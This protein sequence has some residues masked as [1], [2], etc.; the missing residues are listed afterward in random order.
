M[1]TIQNANRTLNW[2]DRVHYRFSPWVYT[3]CIWICFYIG[4]KM[5]YRIGFL[6]IYI[7]YDNL[8]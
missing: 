4:C 5:I 6:S 1:N 8:S 7:R 2:M 3:I